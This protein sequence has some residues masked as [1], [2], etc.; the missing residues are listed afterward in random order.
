ME[1]DSSHSLNKGND[2]IEKDKL[3]ITFALAIGKYLESSNDYIN[4]MKVNKKYK[5]L[6]RIYRYN[7]IEDTR[8]FKNMETQ[9]IY[10]KNDTIVKDRFLYINWTKELIPELEERVINKRTEFTKVRAKEYSS[11]DEFYENMENGLF[12]VKEGYCI[13][14]KLSFCHLSIT[15]FNMIL[16]IVLPNS[17]VYIESYS[18]YHLPNLQRIVLPM[19][20][21]LSICSSSIYECRNLSTVN[22]PINFNVIKYRTEN[23]PFFFT[24]IENI[25]LP[26]NA[27]MKQVNRFLSKKLKYI[28]NP[29]SVNDLVTIRVMI[30]INNEIEQNLKLI[31]N[32]TIEELRKQHEITVHFEFNG[33]NVKKVF[34]R[35]EKYFI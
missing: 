33:I 24:N 21:K 2:E 31:L 15:N 17:L 30:F 5:N 28:V 6:T 4:L 14:K 19:N 35:D 29:I 3:N 26:K 25:I 20:K 10:T 27:K 32:S 9:H 13:L 7:P 22:F 11:S 16:E 34:T 12:I 1:E 8:L 23:R 18:V